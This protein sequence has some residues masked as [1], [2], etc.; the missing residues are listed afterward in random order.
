VDS[1]I[2][3]VSV[4]IPVYKNRDTV[5]T[6]HSQLVETLS[7]LYQEFEIVFVDDHCP[8]MSIEVLSE[9]AER[10]DRVTVIGMAE[11]IG[12]QNAVL[13][14]LTHS[15]GKTAVIM[16][17][18]LQ[19]PPGAIPSLLAK[20]NEG[21]DVVFAGRRGSYQAVSRL[22]TSRLY[23]WTL[24]IITGV[25]TDAGLFMAVRRDA[26]D[27]VLPLK[28]DNPHL[29]AML[30]VLNLRTT[31]LPVA[32][33]LRPSGESAYTSWM[34]MKVGFG[35]AFWALMWKLGMRKM[36]IE[37]GNRFPVQPMKRSKYSRAETEKT[38]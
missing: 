31:S 26:I 4:I 15:H 33:D 16:D 22:F 11:N 8:Q 32:R 18:D 12:Q 19:D 6:L 37:T 23:K 2:P 27:N 36:V 24:H 25:P 38:F 14:G 29:V 28:N 21:Y 9:L 20:L 13:A 17:A 34:R 35:A 1:I 30:G 10:D 3:N 5:V 7:G